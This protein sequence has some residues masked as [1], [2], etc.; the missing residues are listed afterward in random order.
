MCFVWAPASW[1]T[2][3]GLVQTQA[4]AGKLQPRQQNS[5]RNVVRRLGGEVQAAWSSLCTKNLYPL[6]NWGK[7]NKETCLQVGMWYHWEKSPSKSEPADL[8]P[9]LLT[10]WQKGHAFTAKF[11]DK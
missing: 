8:L 7:T 4:G 6:Y 3:E 5:S 11:S 1:G 2:G 9:G 10:L